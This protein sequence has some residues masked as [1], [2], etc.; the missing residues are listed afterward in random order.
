MVF[1]NIAI[2]YIY[3]TAM[4]AGTIGGKLFGAGGADFIICCAKKRKS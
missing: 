2:D 1:F 4:N 3:N